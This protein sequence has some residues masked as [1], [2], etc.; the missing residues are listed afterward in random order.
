M[1]KK[2]LKKNQNTLK[3]LNRKSHNIDYLKYV[4]TLKIFF[5]TRWQIKS[6]DPSIPTK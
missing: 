1:L 6:H 3:I 4:F 2:E 5:G